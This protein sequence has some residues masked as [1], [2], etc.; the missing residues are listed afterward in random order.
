MQTATLTGN[1]GTVTITAGQN[2]GD[3]LMLVLTQDATG[4]RTFTWP[5][6]AK[7]VGGIL[8]LSVTANAVDVIRFTWDG[9]N[10]REVSRAL[11]DS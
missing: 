2:V 7:V 9:T 11:G 8:T 1:V 5:T 4:G 3:E 10:W 6:N